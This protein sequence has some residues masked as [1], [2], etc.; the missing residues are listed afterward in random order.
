MDMLKAAEIP[1]TKR[2]REIIFAMPTQEDNDREFLEHSRQVRKIVHDTWKKN[3]KM[4]V[5]YDEDGKKATTNM[6]GNKYIML[7]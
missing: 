7:D 6:D 3:K 2:E 1:V 4:A 5:L